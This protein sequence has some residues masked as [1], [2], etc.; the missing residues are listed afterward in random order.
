MLLG[1]RVG[2]FLRDS[3]KVFICSRATTNT[4]VD[5]HRHTWL[6]MLKRPC[7][8]CVL[9]SHTTLNIP[10]QRRPLL[11][12]YIT[13]DVYTYGMVPI[14]VNISDHFV[15]RK[16][17]GCCCACLS[18]T[19]SSATTPET[20][21]STT[22]KARLTVCCVFSIKVSATWQQVKHGLWRIHHP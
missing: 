11:A 15:S 3:C 1:F 22:P 12:N 9:P 16:H 5:L 20:N 10:H 8:A 21:D 19:H 6:C 4:V 14:A 17:V 2:T 18:D 13:F 7:Y